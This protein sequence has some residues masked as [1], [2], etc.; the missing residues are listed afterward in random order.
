MSLPVN[1]QL[2]PNFHSLVTSAAAS[3]SKGGLWIA[4]FEDLKSLLQAMKTAL[5]YE[6]GGDR[7]WKIEAAQAIITDPTYQTNAG[8]IFCQAIDIP[9]EAITTN[10]EGNIVY[11]S[12]LRTYVAQGREAFPLMRMTLL[13]TNIS[14]TENVLRPWSI[15]TANFGMI[16]RGKN[17]GKNYRTNLTCYQLGT[18]TNE[19]PAV[20]RTMNF[21]DICCVNVNNE[22]LNYDAAQRPILREAQFA[23]HY[24][25]IDTETSNEFIL[26]AN[27]GVQLPGKPNAGTQSTQSGV[28]SALTSGSATQ[29]VFNRNTAAAESFRRG[30]GFAR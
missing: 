14:F 18:F 21:Y 22:E 9:G 30:A 28:A 27:S 3:I 23:Y 2:I 26:E 12:Y 13:D 8:C 16:A 1:V 20:I 6:P 15:A 25:T 17:S 7:S 5:Q 4:V 19:I 11:N 10:P 29:A 24:Y